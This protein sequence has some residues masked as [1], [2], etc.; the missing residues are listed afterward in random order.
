V[1]W[2]TQEFHRALEVS[3]QH[4][5]LLALAFQ[6]AAGGENLLSEIGG[7]V[8]QWRPCSLLGGRRG[9]WGRGAGVVRPHYAL[10]VLA[11]RVPVG[12]AQ[13]PEEVGQGI[14]IQLELSLEGAI[15]HTASLAQ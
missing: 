15:G 5:D 7:G 2:P 13:L 8:R 11:D 10:L 3:K 9:G 12:I 6:G 1:V 14:R 4:R